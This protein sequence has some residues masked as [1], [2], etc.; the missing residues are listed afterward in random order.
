MGHSVPDWTKPALFATG[1]VGVIPSTLTES[2][3]AVSISRAAPYTVPVTG[4]RTVNGYNLQVTGDVDAEYSLDA[5][6][7][8][9]RIY[10]GQD[11]MLNVRM[12][13]LRIRSASAS[14]NTTVDVVV[15][16]V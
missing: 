1:D 4:G 16:E 8:W 15:Y 6:A 7:T 10:A 12:T 9:L 14:Q 3:P 5:G 2:L 11:K 13:G